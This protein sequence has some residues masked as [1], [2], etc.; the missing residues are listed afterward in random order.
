M[1]VGAPKH[2]RSQPGLACVLGLSAGLLLSP[3]GDAV[4]GKGPAV[5]KGKPARA[6]RGR[7]GVKPPIQT[8]TPIQ[9]PTPTPPPVVPAAAPVAFPSGAIRL[10][11]NDG[12]SSQL[13]EAVMASARDAASRKYRLLDQAKVDELLS[14]ESSL[15][16][17]RRDECRV[18]VAE[19]L[20]VSR[21]IDI[22]IQSPKHRGL[23]ATVLIFDPAAKGI[24]ADFETQLKRE[25]PKKL[26]S[27]VFEAVERVTNTQRLTA[28]LRLDIRPAGAKV[29]LQNAGGTFRDVP[30]IERDGGKE[31]R[32]FLGTYTVHVEKPGYV[33]RDQSVTVAQT[34][35]SVQIEL[36]TQPVLVKFEWT[37]P[38]ARILVDD[39]PVEARDKEMELPE[40]THHVQALAPR[41]SGYESTV[42]DIEVRQGM[43]PVRIALQR[44]T[45]L[46]IK[47]PRDYTVS[48]DAQVLPPSKLTLHGQ[49]QEA[50]VPVTP[51]AHT[52]TATSWRGLNLTRSP[53]VLPRTS[54]DV[55]LNPPSLVPGIL[56]G[57]LGIGALIAGGVLL[58]L[59]GQFTDST[60][61]N[62][63][64]TMPGAAVL[65]G[66]GGAALLG[67]AIWFGVSA[68]NHPALH[69]SGSGKDAAEA[70]GTGA[71]AA[72][73]KPS[74]AAS[75]R[76]RLVVVP[77]V[78]PTSAGI[79]S[80]VQF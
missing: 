11:C 45:E 60:E 19:Q 58:P 65:L 55:I 57:T 33:P 72:V 14:K 6:G 8:P 63:W 48:V 36:P 25:D 32:V 31:V 70:G 77:Q 4:A 80:A 40:G 21:L 62:R 76:S 59:N 1:P 46:H 30:E 10:E 26:H 34:G 79:L 29:R 42:T 13:C 9:G 56:L 22:I 3:L 17:C 50:N 51:G 37:P 64:Q 18:A 66:A 78:S 23:M 35:A 74:L 7:P 41:G 44:L 75:L 71:R 49:M 20:S 39:H 47:A 69:S 67:G 24:S 43:D 54:T 12:Q 5:A 53:Q 2:R 15:R 27:A 38:D 52:V 28:P 16:G 61:L 68:A 73:S